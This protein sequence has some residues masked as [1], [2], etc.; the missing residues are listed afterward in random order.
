M[1]QG[2]VEESEL[3]AN[4]KVI[5]SICK[6]VMADVPDI[7]KWGFGKTTQRLLTFAGLEHVCKLLLEWK[8]ADLEARGRAWNA[9]LG[10]VQWVNAP[11]VVRVEMEYWSKPYFFA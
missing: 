1:N 4:T 3:L 2:K 9:W 11:E 7:N 10:S 8:E 6:A 5:A